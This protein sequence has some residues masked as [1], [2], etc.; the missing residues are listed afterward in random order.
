[1][2]DGADFGPKLRSASRRLPQSQ[3]DRLFFAIRPSEPDAQLIEELTQ[4]L[5]RR[6]GLSGPSI[7]IARFHISLYSVFS[8]GEPVAPS[9]ATA[10]SVASRIAIP[11]FAFRF[12]RV[13]SFRGGAEK[14]PVALYGGDS[15]DAVA[16]LQEAV[17]QRCTMSVSPAFRNGERRHI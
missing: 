6:H 5:R 13:A 3:P 16:A 1:M 14:W 9:I 2:F 17:A 8:G 11:S 15:V 7:G 12:D 4:D 10:G